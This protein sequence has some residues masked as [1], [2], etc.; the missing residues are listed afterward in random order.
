MPHGRNC[1]WIQERRYAN[2]S[3]LSG[4]GIVDALDLVVSGASFSG[5]LLYLGVGQVHGD[6][7]LPTVT[8][9]WGDLNGD[10]VIDVLDLARAASQWNGAPV[11]DLVIVSRNLGLSPNPPKDVLGDSP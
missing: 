3:N 7:W 10:Q 1:I 5:S 6:T 8:I 4:D 11:A 2:W 9:L